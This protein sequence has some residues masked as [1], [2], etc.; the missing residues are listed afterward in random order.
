MKNKCPLLLILL[1]IGCAITSFINTVDVSLNQNNNA[2][3]KLIAIVEKIANKHNLT[4]DDSE[5]I[6]GEKICYFGK[7]Y[8]YYIFDLCELDNKI[9]VKFIHEARLSSNSTSGS[10][11]EKE[12]LE[13][14]R[15]TFSSDIIDISYHFNE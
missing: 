5:S 7:S 12:F 10:E 8:H 9:S 6:L 13:V 1:M 11:P 3:L 2:K 15:N 4:K 14:I